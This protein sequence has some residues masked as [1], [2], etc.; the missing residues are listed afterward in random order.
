VVNK[1]NLLARLSTALRVVR[2]LEER[3]T[4][5][6]TI[7]GQSAAIVRSANPQ[8]YK[9]DG[10]AVRAQ[11]FNRH[12]VVH[13]CIRVVSDIVGSVPLKAL[14]AR[15][16]WESVVPES[17]PLQ[18]LLDF[19]GPRFT[20]RQLR[21]SLAVDMLGY[22]NAL[23]QMERPGTRGK[24]QALRR[25]NPEAIQSVFV[26]AEGDARVYQYGDWGGRVQSI[27]AENMI[28]VRD[29]EMSK[30][31]QPDVFGFP[32]GATALA[33]LLAD[34]EAT[35][36]VRQVVTNDGTPTFAILM[37][38][39]ATQED[40]SAIQARYVERMVNRGNRGKPAVF[41]GV[42]DIRPLGFT[43][44]DL[45]FP[46]LRRVSREDICAAFGVDP[47]MIGIASATSDAGL[48]GQQY[49]EAR[50]R[51]VQHTIEP[52]MAAIEDELNHW[53]APEFGDRWIAFDHDV[54]R[55]MVEDDQATSTRV[56]EEFKSSLRTWE[57][58]RRALKL[59]PVPEPTDTIMSTAGNTLIPAAVAGI[60]PTLV[61]EE[62]AE[63]P[64]AA[65]D[66]EPDDVAAEPEEEPERSEQTRSD[67]KRE[68]W[69]R[70]VRELTTR[71]EYFYARARESFRKESAI[72]SGVFTN[73]AVDFD[74]LKR[75]IRKLYGKRGP[76]LDVWEEEFEAVVRTAFRA[77]IQRVGGVGAIITVNSPTVEQAIRMQTTRLA[78]LITEETARQVLAA[79]RASE[80]AGLTIGETAKLI[81]ASV[82][83][84]QMTDTRATR[85]ARTENSNAT[86][87]GAWM[88]AEE[89]GIY[90]SKEWLAFD[91]KETRDSH[92]ANMGLGIVPMD[93]AY[94]GEKGASLQF[95]G[96]PSGGPEDVINCRCVLAY[97]DEEAT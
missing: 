14:R 6:L 24:I 31:F 79:M 11:G 94:S 30:P 46:D 61:I 43:L 58:S 1:P 9:N 34:N 78:E 63:E 84:E 38:D 65:P 57:E 17:D 25:V 92:S 23:I 93:F 8:E 75:E 88:Q 95:P 56:I 81:Q 33:S 77:G 39:E 62:P 21:S 97:Y 32:R 48:S 69:E 55:D 50:A 13:A 27:P 41:G 36:Y 76:V 68:I 51:L 90:R 86:N 74:A 44:S 26:D 83:G 87:R 71:D 70:A 2:G 18:M 85:I 66:D 3:A 28:H 5:P 82:F 19:P 72:V 64:Q 49:V 16:D 60:D 91:D 35:Q 53:L 10:A 7:G 37:H 54:L 59:S 52:L 89:A 45:E 15:G 4:Y 67:A 12:P 22:G 96:D 42:K 29:L 20:A 80:V 40:A 47:R 73:R